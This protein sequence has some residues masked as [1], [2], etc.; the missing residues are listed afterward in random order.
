VKAALG[1]L[2]AQLPVALDPTV[3]DSVAGAADRI[4]TVPVGDR[5]GRF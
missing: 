3:A 2:A 5:F 1:A 4:D